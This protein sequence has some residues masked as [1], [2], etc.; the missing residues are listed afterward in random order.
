MFLSDEWFATVDGRPAGTDPA[1]TFRLDN[2][3][4]GGPSGV[5]RYRVAV[6]RGALRACR[7]AAGGPP[8]DATLRMSYRTA[9]DLA[10]GRRTAH[11]AFLAGEVTFAD[12]PAKLQELTGGF[13]VLAE[14][15]ATLRALTTYP[16]VA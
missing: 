6:E 10:S 2:V 11:D 12:D 13:G 9:V 15:L 8:P 5:V 4:T 7:D 16:E 1:L 3:V 14:A